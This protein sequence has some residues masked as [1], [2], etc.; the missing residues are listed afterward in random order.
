[1]EDCA[2]AGSS[3][4]RWSIITPPYEGGERAEVKKKN[5]IMSHPTHLGAAAREQ[6]Q[7]FLK[8]PG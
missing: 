6:Y 4:C 1:M 5:P 8:L 2:L 7:Q 3:Q